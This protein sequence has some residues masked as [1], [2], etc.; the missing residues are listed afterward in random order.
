[1]GTEDARTGKVVRRPTL[2]QAL[3]L[4][5]S[6]IVTRDYTRSRAWARR[7]H[8]QGRWYG[9]RWWSYYDPQWASFGLWNLGLLKLDD[10][11]LLRLDDPALLEASRTIARRIVLR[12]KAPA[13]PIQI[14]RAHV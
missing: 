12:P 3:G 11:E 7:M 6:D 10:V 4:R 1:M 5:P 9:A 13:R 14:G 2:L 8:A